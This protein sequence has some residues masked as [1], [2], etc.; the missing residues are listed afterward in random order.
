MQTVECIFLAFIFR[1]PSVLL[2]AEDS[3]NS[4]GAR[5]KTFKAISE[6]VQKKDAGRSGTVLIHHHPSPSPW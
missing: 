4:H 1:N 6:I 3:A 5:I 2:S